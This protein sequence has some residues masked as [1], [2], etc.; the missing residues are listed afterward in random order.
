MHIGNNQNL[1]PSLKIHNQEMSSSNREKYLGDVITS[2]AKID[3]NIQM[4][5]NKGI[6]ICN[7]ILS[8]LKEVSFGV[9]HFE[10]GLLFRTTQL[11]NGILF[12]TEAL[13][14]ITEKHV[15]LLEDCDKYL[16]RSLFNAE[17]GNPIESFN[18]ETSTVPLRFVLRG[19][20]I[21]YYWTLLQ[22]GQEELAKRVF[23]AM[24]EFHVKGDWYSQVK[25]YLI[26]CDIQLSEEEI[27]K[28][29]K[30]QFKKLVDTKIREKSMEYLT[31]LQIKHSKSLF[32]HQGPKMQEYLTTAQLTIR[33]K[34]LLFKLRSG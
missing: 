16:M 14:S 1:C 28:M 12:N 2:N 8:V 4:R 10:M 33:Q 3:E 7:Q 24:R 15:L 32:L 9:F 31:E 5:H 13:F 17:M 25:E 19:R 30:F 11:L 27:S 26:T 21:M 29:T 20:R 23:L 34:Q 18:I 6:G 22:K